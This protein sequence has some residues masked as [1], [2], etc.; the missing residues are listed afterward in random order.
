MK[1][2]QT[3]LILIL[4]LCSGFE[5]SVF[6][7]NYENISNWR[8]PGYQGLNI[9]ETPKDSSSTFNGVRIL[10]GGDFT[11]Q[12]QSIQHSTSNTDT[13]ATLGSNFNLP[14]ANFNI[15]AQLYDGIRMCLTT[16]LSSRHHNE[17]WVKGGYM[18]F[19]KLDFIRKDFLKGLMQIV[20]IRTGLDEI[21]YGD[22]HFRRT[23][24][25]RAI[26]NPFVG[27]YIMDA[28]ST[29]VFGEITLQKY[30]F[31]VVTG[32]SNGKLNQSVIKDDKEY[33]PSFYAKLG[34][35]KFIRSEIRIRNTA[36]FYASPGYD[37]GQY[38]YSGDRT[39]SRYYSVMQE[40]NTSDNFRSG[41]FSPGF[42]KY[43][44][45]QYNPFLQYKGFEFFGILE[46][47]YGDQNDKITGGSYIQIGTELIYRFG[48]NKTMYIG[49]RYNSVSGEDAKDTS[50]KSIERINFGGGWFITENILLKAEYMNQ[51]YWGNGWS[52]MIY[53]GGNFNGAVVEAVIG[54]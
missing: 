7:Q 42:S 43:Y 40:K 16:Y 48:K 1:A 22:A 41:R 14:T 12:F 18:Q 52:G 8:K 26:Y 47:V 49:G 15:N 19:D 20:T 24:N 30:R 31:L 3:T 17:T 45:I 53:E 44:S 27:N 5:D 34:F 9:Y 36:S 2:I 29:E 28:F 54:F 6:S 50:I 39:G 38:L 23:D 37:N 35:D 46:Y 4:F 13:L 33:K 11:L 10:V 32:I 21:N 25:A 51:N